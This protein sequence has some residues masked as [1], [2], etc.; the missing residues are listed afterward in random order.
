[1]CSASD[2][3]SC[4]IAQAHQRDL[5]ASL[6]LVVSADITQTVTYLRVSFECLSV[7]VYE[8][9]C[10][11]KRMFLCVHISPRVQELEFHIFDIVF[12][13]LW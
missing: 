1:M 6:D 2:L 10:V 9:V 7:Q 3:P 12:R 5:D 11:C 4:H 13:C 8:Y